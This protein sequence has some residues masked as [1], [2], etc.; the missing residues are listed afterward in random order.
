MPELKLPV[1]NV[2]HVLAP[3]RAMQ[4]LLGELVDVIG[5][6]EVQEPLQAVPV[7]CLHL[8]HRLAAVGSSLAWLEEEEGA[9]FKRPESGS[10]A[11]SAIICAKEEFS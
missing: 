5:A 11:R 3:R 10:L 9:H 7:E 1:R 4:L 6:L 2:A 8:D